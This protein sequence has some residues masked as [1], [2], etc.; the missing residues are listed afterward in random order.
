MGDAKFGG[1]G[2]YMQPGGPAERE[3]REAA[4]IDPAAH[5]GDAHPVRHAGVDQAEDPGRRRRRIDAELPGQGRDHPRGGSRVQPPPSAE[6]PRRVEIAQHKIGIGD[7]RLGAA[8][9][10][11]RRPW[12]GARAL[13]P[14]LE[15]A[16]AIQPRDRTAAGAQRHDI[17]AGQGD[18][19][20]ADRS[21]AGQGRLAVAHQGDVGAGAAHVEGDE[22][23]GHAPAGARQRHRRRDPAGGTRQRRAGRQKRGFLHRGDAAMGED[24][25][26][27]P[28]IATLAQARLQAA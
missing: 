6:E 8:L 22:V 16:R 10:V 1:D 13:W 27:I 26:Q 14:D 5:R 11:A 21:P 24:D 18:A 3:Q 17:E 19:R 2:R 9:A 12:V 4:R 28:R 7:G 20:L 15:Q 25:E 23:A